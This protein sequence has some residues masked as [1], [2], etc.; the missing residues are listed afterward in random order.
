MVKLCAK[1]LWSRSRTC[2]IVR[3]MSA[4]QICLAVALI[5]MSLSGCGNVCDQM[6]DA[7][8]DLMEGCFGSWESSW[9]DQSYANREAFVARCYNVWGEALE[10]LDSD[11]IERQEFQARCRVQLEVALTD[12]DCES[13]LL[14]DP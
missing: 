14:I 9:Q 2:P 12:S 4:S 7:Q 11:S 8:A 5:A 6:C 1:A 10:A 3:A 13:L